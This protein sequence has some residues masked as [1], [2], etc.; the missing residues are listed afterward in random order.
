MNVPVVYSSAYD[1]MLCSLMGETVVSKLPVASFAAV[2]KKRSVKIIAALEKYSG[3]QFRFDVP[4]FLVSHLPELAISSPLTL[5]Y[6]KDH[7]RLLYILVHEL[8]HELLAQ[9][10]EKVALFVD[11]MFATHDLEFRHHIPV[12]LLQKK[13]VTSVFGKKFFLAQQKKDYSLPIGLV[14]HTVDEIFSHYT[15][16]LTEFLEHDGLAY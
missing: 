3:L 4:C 11:T 9:N 2:W 10:K 1:K 12:L 5:R 8:A 7:D 13:V 16:T 6:Q 15:S 14:W